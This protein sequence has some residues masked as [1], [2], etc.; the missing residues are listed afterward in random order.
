[1][2]VALLD[3]NVLLALF[4]EEHLHHQVAHEWFA[5]NGKHGWA[6]CPLTENG[7]F[8]I[9]GDPARVGHHVPMPEVVDLFNRFCEAGHHTFWVDDLSFRD[10]DLFHVKSMRGHKQVTDVY[11]LGLAVKRKGRL[12]TFDQHVQPACVKGARR[13]HLEVLTPAE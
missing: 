1:M 9:L 12:V 2:T 13:E 11:L 7:L 8:R 5:D 3:V 4:H 6:S 10:Q